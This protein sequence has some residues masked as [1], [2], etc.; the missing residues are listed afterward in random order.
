MSLVLIEEVREEDICRR[1]IF[2][3]F[4]KE[5]SPIGG[6]KSYRWMEEKNE[7]FKSKLVTCQ[8]VLSIFEGYSTKK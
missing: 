2:F 4:F 1:S 6:L 8:S 5:Q 3:F 7:Q